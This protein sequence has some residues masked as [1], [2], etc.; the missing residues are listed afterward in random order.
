MELVTADADSCLAIFESLRTLHTERWTKRGEPGVLA[1]PRV[2]AWHR[3]ALP[4]LLS[5]G[6]LRLQLLQLDRQ[7]LG[8]LYSLIDAQTRTVGQR[9]QY[10]YLTAFSSEH[11]ELRPGTLLLAYAIEHAAQ[12]GIAIIDMLR[13]EEAYK[14]LWHLRPTPTCGLEIRRDCLH[15]FIV[16][17]EGEP[18]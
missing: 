10:F 6:L 18:S 14:Q 3:Q 8:V 2:L 16:A 17:A 13:G 7:P 12:Q 5:A 9:T 11:A 15:N 1:D 4:L